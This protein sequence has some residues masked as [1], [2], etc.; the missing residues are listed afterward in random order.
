M[1]KATIQEAVKQA[2][3]HLKTS[4]AGLMKENESI[5][6]TISIELQPDAYDKCKEMAERCHISIEEAA[7]RLIHSSL[8]E[9]HSAGS[10]PDTQ[11]WKQN[12]LL[13]L[14]SMITTIHLQKKKE[15]CDDN[16]PTTG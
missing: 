4:A 15:E 11:R 6:K 9:L 8:E 13:S 7:S 10:I 1:D 3:D 12:P 5:P 14:D 2:W 16:H